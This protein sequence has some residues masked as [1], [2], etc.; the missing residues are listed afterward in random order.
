MSI[1]IGEIGIAT[2]EGAAD[3]PALEVPSGAEEIDG[4]DSRG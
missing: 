3:A 4:H 2:V 1:H